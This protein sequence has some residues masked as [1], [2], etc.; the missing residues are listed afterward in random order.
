MLANK[1]F[2]NDDRVNA[3]YNIIQTLDK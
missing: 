3:T 1:W 2:P